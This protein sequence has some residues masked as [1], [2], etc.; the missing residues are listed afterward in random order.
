M[1][2]GAGRW[3]RAMGTAVT[4]LLLAVLGTTAFSWWALGPLRLEPII[5]LVV[6][7]GYRL[8]LVLG[9]MVVMFLGYVADLI[10]G[11]VM[12]LNVVI[13]TVVYVICQLARRKLDISSWPFQMLSVGVL[14]ILAHLLTAGAMTLTVPS[15][16]PP[17]NLPLLLLAQALINAFTAPLFFGLNEAL[18]GILAHFG[19]AERKVSP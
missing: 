2:R 14:T 6:S 12:G 10:S 3:P 13:F 15:Y 4:G 16:A 17:V 7:A 1:K 5:V 18:V 8:P 11:G 19:P 9:F